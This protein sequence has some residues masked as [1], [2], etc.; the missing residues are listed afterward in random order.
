MRRAVE[1]ALVAKILGLLEPLVGAGRI[2]AEVAAEMSFDKVDRLVETHGGEGG[3]ADSGAA[4]DETSR[5]Y[6]RSE[7]SVGKVVRLT[8]AVLVDEAVAGSAPADTARLA[9]IKTVVRDA[10]GLDEARGDRLSLVVMPF[11]APVLPEGGTSSGKP[12][13]DIVGTIERFLRPAVGL[14]A[15]GVLLVLALKVV[16]LP[17]VPAGGRAPHAP[18]VPGAGTAPP[19]APG[20]EGER[21]VNLQVVRGWLKQ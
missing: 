18:P 16:R 17:A 6:Q 9:R 5:E 11:G 3:A 4:G 8:A 19:G 1:E 7:G 10:I 20:P 21:E 15:L 12:G 2:R 14:L 13:P